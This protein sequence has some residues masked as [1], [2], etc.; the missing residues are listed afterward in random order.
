MFFENTALTFMSQVSTAGGPPLPS[1]YT[2]A[3][4]SFFN[5]QPAPA[6]RKTDKYANIGPTLRNWIQTGVPD[7]KAKIHNEEVFVLV[8]AGPNCDLHDLATTMRIRNVF[9]YG[10]L[11]YLIHGSVKHPK[12]LYHIDQIDH[13]GAIMGDIYLSSFDERTYGAEPH[14]YLVQCRGQ[15]PCPRPYIWL[16]HHRPRLGHQDPL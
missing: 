15:R 10:R 14:Q 16:H 4:E 13:T 7:G 1:T 3:P 2:G 8:G 6:E 12:Q 5:G 11:G 9:P